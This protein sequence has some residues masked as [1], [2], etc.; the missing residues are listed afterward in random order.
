MATE[1]IDY[2]WG[3]PNLEQLRGLGITGV[4]RYVTGSG[5]KALSRDEIAQIRANNLTLTLVYETTGQTVKGGNVAGRADAQSALNAIRTLGLPLSV[6]YFAVDY[7]MQPAEYGLLDAYLDG[8]A[9]VIGKD[10]TGVYA[11]VNPCAHAM[12]RGYKA[13][14]TYAWSGGRVAQGIKIYQY[15]NGQTVAGGSVD[16]NRTSLDDYGQV[17]WNGRAP[18]PAPDHGNKSNDE[19]ASEVIAGQWGNGSDRTNRLTAAGYSAWM[20]TVI[21]NTQATHGQYVAHDYFKKI[22]IFCEVNLCFCVLCC[23]LAIAVLCCFCVV[24]Y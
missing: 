21:I 19:I 16:R 9:G 24:V 5:G 3:H 2:S 13:W 12:S 4:I 10:R 6:V 15:S 14:Q 8:A 7:D 11:G 17:R 22:I 23:G 1:L 20:V 18:A